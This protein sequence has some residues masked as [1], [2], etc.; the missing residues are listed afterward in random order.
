MAFREIRWLACLIVM[1]VAA[2]CGGGGATGPQISG[3]V[4]LDGAPLSYGVINFEPTVSGSVSAATPIEQGKFRFPP[5]H[6]LT[7]G[8]Y[9]VSIRSANPPVHEQDPNKAMELAS[10]PAPPEKIL[11]KYNTATELTQVIKTDAPNVLSFA[12]TSK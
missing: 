3:E 1:V 7:A 10:Q 9:K 6:G 11:P 12:V 5:Q 4:T 8:T 2:G